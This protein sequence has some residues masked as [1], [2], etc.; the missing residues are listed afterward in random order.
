[1]SRPA[2]HAFEQNATVIKA[3]ADIPAAS[4]RAALAAAD[5]TSATLKGREWMHNMLG[6]EHRSYNS[7]FNLPKVEEFKLGFEEVVKKGITVRELAELLYR[8]INWDYRPYAYPP[9]GGH[10]RIYVSAEKPPYLQ[11][12]TFKAH[13]QMLEFM[14]DL[15]YREQLVALSDAACMAECT[16]TSVGGYYW[17]RL[18][19]DAEDLV[20]GGKRLDRYRDNVEFVRSGGRAAELAPVFAADRQRAADRERLKA[21][22]SALSAAAS[23]SANAAAGPSPSANAAAAVAS[24]PILVAAPLAAATVAPEA[25]PVAANAL[26]IR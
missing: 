26:R 17:C 1:M 6:A 5:A 24:N 13:L 2:S 25:E 11:S 19:D 12:Q 9:S 20:T 14:I 8:R 3:A 15:G 7:D 4:E 22:A 21:A 23:A 10:I 18:P 16:D